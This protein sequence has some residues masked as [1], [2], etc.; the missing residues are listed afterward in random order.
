M[1]IWINVFVQGEQTPGDL[2]IRTP[3]FRLWRVESKS[4]SSRNEVTNMWIKPFIHEERSNV[5]YN[6]GFRDLYQN[7]HPAG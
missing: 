3:G 2:S 4:L 5:D 6:F 1:G 7:L